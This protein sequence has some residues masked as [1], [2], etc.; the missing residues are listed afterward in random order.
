MSKLEIAQKIIEE[1]YLAAQCGIFDCRNYV[2]D[3]MNTLY[4]DGELQIDICHSWEY[5]EVFGLTAEDFKELARFYD[6]LENARRAK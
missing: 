2:G 1:N 3:H 6:S 5:F 4:D